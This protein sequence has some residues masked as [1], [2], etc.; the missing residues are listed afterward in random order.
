MSVPLTLA[1]LWAVLATVV[2]LLPMRLQMVPG[3]ALLL[4]APVLLV[5]IGWLHGVVWALVAALGFLSM[6]RRPLIYFGRKALGL[7]VDDPREGRA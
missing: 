1:C 7:P 6:F 5:W 4:A 3:M 2:A